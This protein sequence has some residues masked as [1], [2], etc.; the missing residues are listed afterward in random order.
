MIIIDEH[1]KTL[2]ENAHEILRKRIS[3]LLLLATI[4]STIGSTVFLN[5]SGLTTTYVVD[6]ILLEM[7]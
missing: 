1:T 4:G 7:P 3:L 2:I 6:S 5:D